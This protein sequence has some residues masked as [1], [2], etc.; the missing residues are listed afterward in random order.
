MP[1]LVQAQYVGTMPGLTDQNSGSRRSV[2]TMFP[3][4]PK[5]WYWVGQRGCPGYGRP[6]PRTELVFRA[7]PGAGPDARGPV[8]ASPVS[9]SYVWGMAKGWAM[10]RAIPPD[11]YVA[12][13][14]IFHYNY[15]PDRE[16]TF[17]NYMCVRRDC[18]R[19]VPVG[20]LLWDDHGTG[21]RGDGSM[22]VVSDGTDNP[23]QRFC[24]Q[25]DYNPPGW[26]G[27]SIDL[28]VVEMVARP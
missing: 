19:A 2:S 23:W 4:C 20:P 13:G 9:W 14:D 24:V 28:S 1:H 3:A 7:H 10:W 8:L 12:V 5:D 21:A 26:P 27:Y 25:P 15:R 18:L 17:S 16:E 22:W 11:G 6:L